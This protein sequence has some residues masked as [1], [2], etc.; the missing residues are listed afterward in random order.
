M[1]VRGLDGREHNWRLDKY[2]NKQRVDCS[3]F[4]LRARAFL[5]EFYPACQILEEVYLPGDKLYLD[6]YIPHMHTA[7]ECQGDQHNKFV[8]HFHG[9][10]GKFKTQVGRDHRKAEW[11]IQNRIDLVYF[12]PE[13]KDEEWKIKLENL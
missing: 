4:H 2:I 6:F 10:K 9:T 1:K 13:E 8:Q 3:K 12:K 11:C 7:I 5:A